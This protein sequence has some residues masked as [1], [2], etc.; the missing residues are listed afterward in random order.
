MPSH[1]QRYR[2]ITSLGFAP[3]SG[4]PSELSPTAESASQ[5]KPY[6]QPQGR[7]RA[8]TSLGFVPHQTSGKTILPPLAE[9]KRSNYSVNS[10]QMNK[11]DS[12]VGSSAYGKATRKPPRLGQS[13]YPNPDTPSRAGTT[14][15]PQSASG[16]S[17]RRDSFAVS[18]HDLDTA[19]LTLDFG[20]PS[21]LGST[22]ADS[23]SGG[24]AGAP[25]RTRE[26][27]VKKGEAVLSLGIERIY[28]KLFGHE[29]TEQELKANHIWV[30]RKVSD[31]LKQQTPSLAEHFKEGMRTMSQMQYTA[32]KV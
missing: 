5:K 23:A 12:R 2:A 24:E 16:Q 14:T 20:G 22:G 6:F 30:M 25:G 7:Q 18:L 15:R 1:L 29:P 9:R 10:S 21:G 32:E 8:T 28:K 3:K 13:P 11:N 31:A 17:S 4:P 27:R 26:R 19:D